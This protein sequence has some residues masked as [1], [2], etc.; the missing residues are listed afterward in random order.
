MKLS[1]PLFSPNLELKK[2]GTTSGASRNS[3]KFVNPFPLAWKHKKLLLNKKWGAGRGSLG[4]IV[5]WTKRTR[6]VKTRYP[7][8]NYYFRYIGVSFIAG[9]IILP[10]VNKLL[11]LLFTSSGAASYLPT[12]TNHEMFKLTQ[13]TS[14]FSERKIFR[15][16]SNSFYPLSVLKQSFFIIRQLPKNKPISLI[17]SLPGKGVQYARSTGT[18][19]TALKMDSRV[20]TA[21]I[22]LPSGVKKVFST[23]SIG[24]L[25]KVAIPENR[26]S[27]N[28]SA[29]FYK[30][31]GKKSKVRGVA[32]NPIDHPHGGRAKAIRYQRTPWGKTTKFK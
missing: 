10:K 6:S 2:I 12:S 9:F 23:F 14:V 3:T 32:M 28:A 16:N 27:A 29:G 13:F 7:F 11:S 19:A 25:G 20:S 15:K 22:K 26:K 21:L 5:V 8:I 30:N 4:R 18:F 1:S 17:E 31:H 24:S